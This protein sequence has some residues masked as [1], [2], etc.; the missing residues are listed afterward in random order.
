LLDEHD[1]KR[2]QEAPLFFD[3]ISG[4]TGLPGREIATPA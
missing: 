3:F 4:E 2:L 1:G